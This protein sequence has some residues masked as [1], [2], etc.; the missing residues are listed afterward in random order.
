MTKYFKLSLFKGL[1]ILILL[2]FI[3]FTVYAQ[4]SK[5]SKRD[6]IGKWIM[7]NQDAKAYALH[8]TID[9][10]FKRIFETTIVPMTLNYGRWNIKGNTIRLKSCLHSDDNPNK[11]RDFKWVWR[12]ERFE[13][14]NMIVTQLYQDIQ[15]KYIKIE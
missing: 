11:C 10:R 14:N 3:Q 8:D 12:I 5:I 15:L 2:A 7:I 6:L 9:F 13:K 4:S 1:L